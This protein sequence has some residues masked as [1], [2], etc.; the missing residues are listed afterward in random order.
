M[1]SEVTWQSK[2][3]ETLL[4][5]RFHISTAFHPGQREIIEQLLQG[6]RLL[7]IQRTRWGRC[8]CYQLARLYYPHL[9]LVFSP[10]KVLMRDQCQ[11]CNSVYSIPDAIV[12]SCFCFE[13]NRATLML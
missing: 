11:R 9:T 10:L 12:G 13:E 4:K 7:V 2:P 8:L 1:A 3:Q 5:E 6:K